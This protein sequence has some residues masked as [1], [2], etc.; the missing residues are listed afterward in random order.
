MSDQRADERRAS[1]KKCRASGL[2]LKAKL[3]GSWTNKGE[4]YLIES[5]MLMM[6]T[7]Q[8]TGKLVHCEYTVTSAQA[9]LNGDVLSMKRVGEE[10]SVTLRRKK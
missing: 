8:S 3:G 4:T 7:N 1:L 6:R 2:E 10:Q 5:F 9:K